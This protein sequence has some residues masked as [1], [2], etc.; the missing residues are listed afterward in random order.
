[1]KIDVQPGRYV[2]AVSGGVD[3]M[4]LLNLLAHQ[5]GLELVVAHVDHGIRAD[6]V[7]DR[8]LVQKTAKKLQLPF[9]FIELELGK[10]TS[11]ETARDARYAFLTKVKDDHK[12]D[13]IITA[14]H[15]D[16][17]L[18]TMC[19]N[20]LRGTHNRG[21]SSLKNTDNILR[22]LLNYSKEEIREYADRQNIEWC[23]DSTNQDETY[24]R[25]WVRRLIVPKLSANQRASLIEAYKKSLSVSSELEEIS[26]K[27][28]IKN[29]HIDKQLIINASHEVSMELVAQWLRQNNLAEFD[30]KTLERIVISAKT[31]ERGKKIPV[32]AGAYVLITKDTLDIIKK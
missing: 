5:K 30:T 25:N 22:P 3:S 24:L 19:I 31:L 29:E 4:V 16:D 1:M 15:Q 17:V 21:L 26:E 9:E 32:Y 8:K 6:S 20:V 2:V 18:E 27:L 10:D 13:A 14:H 7:E 12:A 23:E 11:E 28:Q